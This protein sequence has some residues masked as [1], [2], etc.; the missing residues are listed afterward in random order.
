VG[1]RSYGSEFPASEFSA[2]DFPAAGNTALTPKPARWAVV[3]RPTVPRLRVTPPAPVSVPRAPFV[4]MVLVVV[5]TGVVGILVLNTKINEN[6]FRLEALQR[7]QGKLDRTEAQLTKDLAD[8]ESPNSLA[9]A[10]K[11][12]G[13]VPSDR[14]AFIT[15]PDGKILGVPRPASSQ[16]S[17]SD[18][19]SSGAAATGQ[20]R[21]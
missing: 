5:I 11:R 12:L 2:S 15:L 4:A 13:M 20:L 3:N 16:S 1:A 14:P 6:A 10:A 17:A 21:R 7:Q 18:P 9:A 8:R 19:K